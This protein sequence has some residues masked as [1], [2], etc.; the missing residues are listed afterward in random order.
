MVTREFLCE[1]SWSGGSRGDNSKVPMKDYKNFL[2]FFCGMVRSWDSKF[3]MGQ[4]EQFFKFVLRN[5][6]K[7][8]SMKD[9]RS[10]SKRVRKI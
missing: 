8:K 2:K 5:A 7:R 6:V 10:S 3:T 1:C 4:T 9:I